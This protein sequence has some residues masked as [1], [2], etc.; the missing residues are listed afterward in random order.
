MQTRLPRA[1]WSELDLRPVPRQNDMIWVT[2]LSHTPQVGGLSAC[3]S[4]PTP[5]TGHQESTLYPTLPTGHVRPPLPGQPFPVAL[6]APPPGRM[7][8][9]HALLRCFVSWVLPSQELGRAPPCPGAHLRI[10]T[11]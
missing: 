9:G 8:P 11:C 7:Q 1:A 10:R 2:C 5:S 6:P 4:T 3:T